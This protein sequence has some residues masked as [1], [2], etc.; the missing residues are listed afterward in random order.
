VHSR[1]TALVWLALAGRALAGDQVV[2]DRIEALAPIASAI[3]IDGSD[4]DW[5]GIPSVA[6]D[7]G[8]AG[9]DAARD[10]TSLSIAPLE[11]AL[12]VRIATA[13]APAAGSLDF[14]LEID[15]RGYLWLDLQLGLGDGFEDILWVY[16]EDGDPTLESGFDSQLAIGDAVEARIPYAALAPHLP[17][18]MASALSGPDA[19]SWM[20]VQAFSPVD[21]AVA[22]SY[23]LKPTPYPLD[24][25]RPAPAGP[26]LE[27]SM[28]LAGPWLISQGPF[29]Q[30]SHTGAWAYDLGRVDAELLEDDPHPGTENAHYYAFG[31]TVR[32]PVAGSV[33]FARGS[34]PDRPPR[35]DPPPGSL[36]NLVQI[37]VSPESSVSLYHLRQGS[38]AV[39]AGEGVVAG[40]I[41]GQVGNSVPGWSWPH[42]HLQAEA[43]AGGP[44]LQPIALREVEV[45]LNPGDADPWERRVAS[46]EIQEG[47]LV[48]SAR[49]LC[50]DLDLDRALTPADLALYR[51]AL[52]GST[53]LSVA[54]SA[55][56]TVI[57]SAGPCAL[58]DQVVVAR[59]LAAPPQLPALAQACSAAVGSGTP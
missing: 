33:R 54:A 14:W 8:D 26:A 56:C 5:E 50:G 37:D 2:F 43:P 10:I 9:G 57:G 17:A 59:Q 28:P 32:A 46:W 30:G 4:S 38:V 18:E 24:S 27:M 49:A 58:P 23:R 53:T 7:A 21:R 45:Q 41:I 39:N 42:L 35:T 1:W 3:A 20:R 48:R 16:P 12:L 55:R 36:S 34:E 22:A 51:A 52:I 13:A 19:R 11:D 6:D 29:S 47:L 44:E 25:P 40:Q 31:A 15:F